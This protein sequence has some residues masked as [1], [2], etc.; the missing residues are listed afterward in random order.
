MILY[1]EKLSME[2]VTP[3]IYRGIIFKMLYLEIAVRN[4][5]GCSEVLK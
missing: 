3:M 4:S 2:K 1:V 5:K